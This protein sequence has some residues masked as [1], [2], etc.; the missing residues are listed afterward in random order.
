MEAHLSRV[1]P[2]APRTEGEAWAHAELETLGRERFVPSAIARFLAHSFR[3]AGEVRRRRTALAAQGRRWAAAGAAAWLAL[4]ATGREPF[5]RRTRSGLAWWGATSLMVDWHLGMVEEE[6][7]RPAAL[8]PADACTLLRAWLVP[9]A[10]DA[11]HAAA[12]A[13][14]AATDVL[15]GRLARATRTTR[16]GRDLE[17]LA[18]V[19]FSIAA[20]RGARRS[21][22]LSRAA[23]GAELARLG[24]GVAFT[25]A[26]YFGR[27]QPP[28][29]ALVRAAR[30]T[31]P[32]R[33]AGLL[34]AGAGRR[35]ATNRLVV[36]GAAASVALLAR[37]VVAPPA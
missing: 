19:C 32:L 5:R 4:A 15:D 14:A 35:R 24:A 21:D 6:D 30:L 29:A 37:E 26:T 10:A 3:R 36:V 13:L 17:G 31:T 8:G 12:I 1:G 7:G 22:A 16:A 23:A 20:L 28:S 18:D 27:A 34:V 33:V 2:S 11:P 9:V 25:T